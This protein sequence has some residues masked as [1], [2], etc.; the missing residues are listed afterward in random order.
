HN[1]YFGNGTYDD[2]TWLPTAQ[3]YYGGVALEIIDISQSANRMTFGVRFA[4]KLD[5][6]YEG[7]NTI[8]AAAINFDGQ[9]TD[10]IFYPMPD[11]KLTMFRNGIMMPD[12]PIQLQPIP[13]PYTWDGT[14]AYIPVQAQSMARLYKLNSVDRR[15]S[16]NLPGYKWLSHPIDV[17][18][19]L[20]MPMEILE[21]GESVILSYLKDEAQLADDRITLAAPL[22]SNLLSTDDILYGLSLSEGESFYTLWKYDLTFTNM[23]YYDTTVPADSMVVGLFGACLNDAG[24]LNIIVQCPSSLYVFDLRYSGISPRDGFPV[25]KPDSSSAPIVIGDY[26]NNGKLDII[27]S[28][29]NR[30]RILDHSGSDLSQTGHELGLIDDG[31]ASGTTLLDLDNDGRNELAGSFSMN[32]LVVWQDAG[33][34]QRGYP[35]SFGTRGRFM[36]FVAKDETGQ[37]YLWQASDRGLITR[38]AILSYTANSSHT[39]WTSEYS[40]LRRT[41]FYPFGIPTNIYETENS[42]FVKNET[43]IYPNPLKPIYE[44]R[45]RL[46]VM[47]TTDTQVELKIFDISG[48]MVHQQTG[49]AYAYLRNLDIFDIPAHNLSSGIY[50]AVLK[51]GGQTLQLRFGIEK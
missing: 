42:V 47:T 11:G 20:L 17:G 9:G 1:D 12:F 13:F 51:G 23:E 18:L 16:I 15:Y 4:W 8:P 32:R 27:W 36:P 49:L 41:A 40:N 5:S 38:S 31:I 46:S 2:L 25:V 33:K 24:T 30:I 26:D 6:V 22:I 48:N 50:I 21:T 3:S 44:Q 10:E 34:I 28:S 29:S 45:L 37:H 35:V 39:Q 43:Y 14:D 19:N 7:E